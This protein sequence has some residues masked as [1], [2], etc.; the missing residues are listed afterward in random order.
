MRY[1]GHVHSVDPAA[2]PAAAGERRLDG[3]GKNERECDGLVQ[4][5]LP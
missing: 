3:S 1:V 4:K 5:N 2:V